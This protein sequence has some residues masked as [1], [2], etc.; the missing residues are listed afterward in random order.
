MLQDNL[1]LFSLSLSLSLSCYCLIFL[2]SIWIIY[3]HF[4]VIH[5]LESSNQPSKKMMDT[6][7]GDI[8][9]S[10]PINVQLHVHLSL[11]IRLSLPSLSL[12]LVHVFYGGQ[13]V[14]WSMYNY[15]DRKYLPHRYFQSL[16]GIL[17]LSLSLY[18]QR[19]TKQMF[20]LLFAKC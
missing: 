19:Q 9:F 18:S 7:H 2:L 12:S 13:Q 14:R 3:I 10:S 5:L 20:G 15:F 8:H 16:Y 17:I 1:A 4:L 6:D 11:L